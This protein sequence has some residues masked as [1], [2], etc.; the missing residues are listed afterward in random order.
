MV[1]TH[2]PVAPEHTSRASSTRMR[3][4]AGPFFN[5][6]RVHDKPVMPDPMTTMSTWVGKDVLVD[7]GTLTGGIDQNGSVGLFTGK[8]GEWAILSL[9]TR[10]SASS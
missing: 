4:S 10:Y 7:V 2:L 5:K 9:T 1:C 3:R 8:P 6:V